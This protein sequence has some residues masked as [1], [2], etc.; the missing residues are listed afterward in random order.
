MKPL[1][2]WKVLGIFAAGFGVVIAVNTV[3]A[4]AAIKT[5]PGLEVKN[6][7]VASQSWEAR[8][9]VQEA[10]GWQAHA[11]LDR[12]GLTL[13]L[14]DRAGNPVAPAA[15]EA[16][17]GRAT[18][19]R[20]DQTLVLTRRG[21]AFFAPARVDTG[22]WVLFLTARAADGAE[23]SQRIHLNLPPAAEAKG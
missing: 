20:D 13:R 9:A 22:R 10:L 12:Q 16:R 11:K 21:D 3:L 15:I 8:R 5:F 7:Y 19:A 1:N 6:A 14:T 2:G 18:V 23:F 4:V 17:I